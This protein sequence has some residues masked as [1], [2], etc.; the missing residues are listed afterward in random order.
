MEQ[1]NTQND[2][3]IVR[4]DKQKRIALVAHDSR[5][6]DIINWVTVNKEKLTKHFLCGTGTTAKLLA[7]ATELPITAFNSGPLGGDQQIGSRIVE[8]NIDFMIFFWDP[9]AS[10]PHDPDV[11]ALLRI[12]ALYDIPFPLP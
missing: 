11:K 10:Q 9:L 5:K 7:A 4:M 1:N 2:F 8:G 12:A 3:T 6:Q